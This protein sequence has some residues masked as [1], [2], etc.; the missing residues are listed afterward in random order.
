MS[1][2]NQNTINKTNGKVIY[3]PTQE[4][5]NYPNTDPQDWAFVRIVLTPKKPPQ[6]S[7]M[8]KSK[9]LRCNFGK[10]D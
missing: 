6:T 3:F 4:E 1:V 2:G 8:G 5:M 9:V 7:T 10:K